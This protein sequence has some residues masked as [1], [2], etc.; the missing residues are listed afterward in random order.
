M[1]I[2]IQTPIQKKNGLK[3]STKWKKLKKISIA[4]NL[5]QYMLCVLYFKSEIKTTKKII[6]TL[7]KIKKNVFHYTVE[8]VFYCNIL[9]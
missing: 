4:Y 5:K 7:K 6:T 2:I 9:C 8:L 3:K 1:R